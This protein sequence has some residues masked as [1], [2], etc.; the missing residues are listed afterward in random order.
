MVVETPLSFL[1][2]TGAFIYDIFPHFDHLGTGWCQVRFARKPEK[3]TGKKNL[4]LLSYVAIAF[5]TGFLT[6]Y[7]CSPIRSLFTPYITHTRGIQASAQ[8]SPEKEVSASE[9]RGKSAAVIGL[10]VAAKPQALPSESE[11]VAIKPAAPPEA[12]TEADGPLKGSVEEPLPA[13]EEQTRDQPALNREERAP[14][15]PP[16]NPPPAGSQALAEENPAAGPES[17]PPASLPEEPQ[18]PAQVKVSRGEGLTQIISRYYPGQEK[19]GLQ[20]A[21]LANPA[22]T[23]EDVIYPG[24]VL[25]LPRVNFATGTIQLANQEYYALYGSYYS[26]QSWQGDQPWLKKC[27]VKFLVRVTREATGRTLRRVYLGGYATEE[28]LQEA[29][30]RLERKGQPGRLN[31][32]GTPD[33][34]PTVP[35]QGQQGGAL[36]N[37]DSLAK[38]GSPNH[39]PPGAQKPTRGAAGDQP[40]AATSRASKFKPNLELGMVRRT[41]GA[42]RRACRWCWTALK[43]LCTPN[44]LSTNQREGVT[45]AHNPQAVRREAAFSKD[46]KSDDDMGLSLRHGEGWRE[47]FSFSQINSMVASLTWPIFRHALFQDEAKSRLPRPIRD[48]LAVDTPPAAL[49]GSVP[50]GKAL[51][52]AIKGYVD[53]RGVLHI[54]NEV[55]PNLGSGRAAGPQSYILGRSLLLSESLGEKESYGSGREDNGAP[56]RPV[57]WPGQGQAPLTPP[58]SSSRTREVSPLLEGPIRRYRDNEGVLHITTEEPQKPAQRVLKLEAASPEEAGSLPTTSQDASANFWPLRMVSSSDQGQAPFAPLESNPAL[59]DLS[60][61]LEGP[62]RRYRD[63]DLV[64]HITTE[65]PQKPQQRVHGLEVEAVSPEEPGSFPATPQDAMENSWPVRS[66]SLSS[67]GQAPLAPPA[68]KPATR[69][70]SSLLEGPIR[71]YRDGNGVIHITSKEPQKP[72]QRPHRPEVEVASTE[73]PGSF[74]SMPRDAMERSWPLRKVAWP[75]DK[76]NPLARPKA[77]QRDL[78]PLEGSI[79][80]YRD[81]TGVLHITNVKPISP[82]TNMPLLRTRANLKEARLSSATMEPGQ[83]DLNCWPLRQVSWPGEGSAPIRPPEAPPL[84]GELP[85]LVEAPIRRYRDAKGEIHIDNLAPPAGLRPA[86]RRLAQDQSGNSPGWLAENPGTAIDAPP[87]PLGHHMVAYLD[88]TGRFHILTVDPRVSL[89]KTPPQAIE[90]CLKTRILVAAQAYGLPP[91]LILALIRAE[92]NFVPWAVSPKGAMGLMQLMPDTA[93]SLGVRDPFCPRENIL[94]G[95]RYFRLLLNYFQ[96][97]LPLALAAYNA[98]YGRVVAAGYKIPEIRETQDFVAQVLGLYYLMNKTGQL[99]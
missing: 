63:G 31:Q 66:V 80:S 57:S 59:R 71:R 68:T 67:P 14:A 29:Q 46:G 35:S 97:S 38:T 65:E 1:T 13:N 74:P 99:L 77:P 61:L 16:A 93:T 83:P 62:V 40:G 75:G 95:C 54:T 69:D 44:Y 32:S 33:E 6:A 2:Y 98:G 25:T 34:K 41:A 24:Q 70:V 39:P 52:S 12:R 45:G 88:V 92:S 58:P 23:N 10:A 27:Q 60:P 91:P 51:P 19:I 85:S 50:V 90:S 43:F 53:N 94:A 37:P 11:R 79:R 18:L 42:V 78:P 56:L 49:R 4:W 76:P 9:P 7:L 8:V 5:F 72:E 81:K 73:D 82:A 15:A 17:A 3:S 47:K 28:D 22:I 96:G 48:E 55:P 20:A 21:I 64:F 87:T 86:S 30:H 84:P 26:A 36:G 89:D